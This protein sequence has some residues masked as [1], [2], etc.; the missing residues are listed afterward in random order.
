MKKKVDLSKADFKCNAN[1]ASVSLP[2]FWEHTVGS[3]HATMALRAD[4]QQQLTQC[5]RELG[6]KHVRFHGLLSDDMGTLVKDENELVY[7]F[8]NADEICDFLL[9]I[10]MR[11]F[12]ELSFMP[13]SLAS[14]LDT[15][16]HYKGN[17]T[18]PKDYKDWETLIKKLVNHWVQR[19]GIAEVSQWFFEVWNEPNLDLFW[20]GT[21]ADYF[22]LYLH[23]SKVIKSVHRNL[24]VGGP[25]TA[26]NA[27]ITEFI[28]YC[29]EHKVPLDFISTHHYPTDAFGK[30]GD[31]TITQLSKSKQSVLQNDAEKVRNQAGDR[32]VYYTEWATSSN[33][34]DELHDMPYAAC[35]ILK[36]V[37]EANGLVEGYSY[38]TFSDIFEE[39]YFSSV[40]FHGGFGLMNIYGI[41]KPAY[42]AFQLLHRLGNELLKVTGKHETVDVWIVRKM[43]TINILITNWALPLHPIKAEFV[44]VQLDN[45]KKIKSSFIEKIDDEHGNARKTWID[46]GSPGSLTATEVS[47][48]ELASALIIEPFTIRQDEGSVFVEITVPSQGLAYLTIE[49][50]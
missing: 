8:F 10:G 25:A 23:T 35:F 42:R 44:K 18:P 24:K 41:P 37:I 26:N 34:F 39:N 1:H 20:E 6:F 9:S 43:D 48:L 7:S 14:G 4:W 50:E 19:Y 49:T 40:P 3:G 29:N 12:I 22:K 46:M 45:I 36:T 15:V 11:P 31:D 13:T 28:D 47:A 21:Q 16:F 33:P 2:H 27:W 17:I 32:P 5:S 30:P 38:W